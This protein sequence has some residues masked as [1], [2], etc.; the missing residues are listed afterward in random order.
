MFSVSLDLPEFEVVKQVFLEDCILLHV[1]K[2]SMEERC[3]FCGFSSS[4]V[5]DWRTRKVRDLSVLGKPLFLFVRVNRYRC[6]NCNEVF[7]QTFESISPKKHQTNRY[8]EFLY[9]MC[10]GSTIQEVSRKEKVPYT[11]V[12]RIFYSIAKEKE[13]ELLEHLENVME[14][15]ELVLSLDEVAVR[16]GHRYETVLIDAQSGSVLA[17]EH[18]RSYDSTQILLTKK[19]LANKCVHTVVMDMWD[20][21]HKAVKSIFPEACIV[22]DKYHVV[23]KVTQALD[24]VRKK[25][26]GLK[27]GRFKLLKGSEKLTIN[28]KQQLD[29]MLEEH[30]ELSYAYFL[31]EL[32]REV[33]QAPNLDTA[34][35]LLEEWIQ[36]AWSSPF[37]SFHQV[38]KT[39]TKWKAQVLQYFLTPFTNGRIEGTNHKIKNIKRRAYGFRN[40]ERFRLRVF[41][42][43]TGKYY[44][45][46]AA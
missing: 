27:K 4:N 22:I 41:L 17:M 3:P 39:L 16:K 33:Y 20:P 35:S 36:L 19:I 10:N 13:M 23:Q 2:N 21:F 12:E 24:Q 8:R 44:K 28:E 30:L 1:E 46:Q 31:K 42:E 43:C 32:F 7:S 5:H 26:P 11:T 29:E 34:D 37:P 40:L 9:H 6:H 18:Q 25:I 14:T 45:N 38:A 15:N